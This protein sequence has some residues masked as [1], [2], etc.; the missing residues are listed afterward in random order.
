MI[1]RLER[2]PPPPRGDVGY[3]RDLR[4]VQGLLACE[5]P[6]RSRLHEELYQPGAFQPVPGTSGRL[7]LEVDLG[8]GL[9]L[10]LQ[11]AVD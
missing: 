8:K 9:H 4:R 10:K 11:A 5:E 6:P 2:L 7:G 1:Q 3:V